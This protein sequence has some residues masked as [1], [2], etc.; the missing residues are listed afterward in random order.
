MWGPLLLKPKAACHLVGGLDKMFRAASLSISD[1][2]LTCL[3]P[4]Y[5]LAVTQTSH[6]PDVEE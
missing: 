5:F 2:L 1:V 4:L 6:N 3:H